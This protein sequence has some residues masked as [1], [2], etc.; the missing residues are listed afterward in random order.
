MHSALRFV[1]AMSLLVGIASG[2]DAQQ[3]PP[4][5]LTPMGLEGAFIGKKKHEPATD[6]SGIAC[7]PPKGMRRICLVINDENH[8]AQFAAIENDRLVAGQS[9][10]LIG[11]K[12]DQKSRGAPPTI[13][14][15]AN[16]KFKDLDG[17]GVAYAEPYFY[18][19][20]SHGCSRN[21]N[22]LRL[23]SF[24]LARVRV[25]SEGR[26]AGSDGK[27][28][29]AADSSQ[30]VETSWRVSDLLGRAGK[31][32]DFFG[33]NPKSDNG[34]NIEGLTVDG[35]TIWLGLR[36][37]VIKGKNVDEA[38]LVRGS[39]ADLF[40]DGHD[41][42]TVFHDVVPLGLDGLGVRDLATLP[43]GRLL[44]LAGAA[45][46]PEVPFKLF[47]FNSATKSD[48][49]GTLP[50]VDGPGKDNKNEL[51][52]AEAVTVLAATPERASIVILFDG[53]ID[54]SPQRTEIKLP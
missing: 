48:L 27:P 54:G 35:D 43:G 5:V 14:C 24:L 45:H 26:P 38:F 40:R 29:S 11:D 19:V 6:I 7:M 13:T 15:E 16:G 20:G 37:P 44:I 46:G 22:E 1:G 49:V 50:A 28:L 25:D 34:L 21:Q 32:G 8:N 30:A 51:G 12:P 10:D 18:V 41:R 42:A 36:A 2:A 4:V 39:V 53:L 33:K 17:E 9:I 52:K 23:S 3:T 47:V 31:A